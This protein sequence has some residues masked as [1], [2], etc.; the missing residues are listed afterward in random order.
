MNWLL[1]H[2]LFREFLLLHLQLVQFVLRLIVVT[3]QHGVVLLQLQQLL[4]HLQLQ[5]ALL[6]QGALHLWTQQN[7]RETPWG[8]AIEIRTNCS[9]YWQNNFSL[10]MKL[11]GG[12]DKNCWLH[13]RR[14]QDTNLNNLTEVY[15][16]NQHLIF[17]NL[18]SFKRGWL[19]W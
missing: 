5:A 16:I 9:Q 1:E 15:C 12:T 8:G 14:T 11:N 19:S 10:W 3:V 6:M 7:N 18:V 17:F 4:L 2:H 13:R